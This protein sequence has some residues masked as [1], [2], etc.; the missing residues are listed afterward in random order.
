M[1]EL[2]FIS[3][4]FH[5]FYRTSPVSNDESKHKCPRFAFPECP[6]GLI[7]TRS[8]F[9]SPPSVSESSESIIKIDK[10]VNTIKYN[11]SYHNI[12][13]ILYCQK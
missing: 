6:G 13:S 10:G 2:H 4:Y 9:P 7:T 1:F 8:T 3:M 12:I 11:I 5:Y